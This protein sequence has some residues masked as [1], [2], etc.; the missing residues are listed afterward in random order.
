MKRSLK[1]VTCASPGM[2]GRNSS[3]YLGE[4]IQLLIEAVSASLF[5]YTSPIGVAEHSERD[6]KTMEDVLFLSE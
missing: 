5:F 3:P 2:E 1:L 6:G 4:T